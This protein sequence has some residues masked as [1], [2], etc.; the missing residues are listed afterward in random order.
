M[1]R[2]VLFFVAT[3]VSQ[4]CFANSTPA[5]W[6]LTKQDHA[7]LHILGSIHVGSEELYPLPAH[8]EQAFNNASQLIVE[9]DMSRVTKSD[10]EEVQRLTHLPNPQRLADVMPIEQ[11][12]TLKAML[13]PLGLNRP[14]VKALQ[15]WFVIISAMH[16]KLEQIG[17]LAAMGID[18][19][20]I[21]SANKV[22]KPIVQL[23]NMQKQIWN[24]SQLAQESE[25]FVEQSMKEL[26]EIDQ[27]APKLLEAWS[28]GNLSKLTTLLIANDQPEKDLNAFQTMMLERN[29]DWF[30]QLTALPKESDAFIVVGTL[31]LTG[32]SNLIE[33]LEQ[34]G[35]QVTSIAQEIEPASVVD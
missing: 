26:A 25:E 24:M 31:H 10:L 28:Q 7:T 16:L 12:R 11:Y 33:L 21:Q 8:I 35:Y 30:E 20:F 13:K 17:Y 1:K 2:M 15:P 19:H 6:Q 3:L 23:E 34:S 18:Q 9:V 22:K 32:E 5:F 27:L 4:F 14:E 29:Q